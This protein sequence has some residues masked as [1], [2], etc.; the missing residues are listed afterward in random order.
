MN[1]PVISPAPTFQV[2]RAAD[3]ASYDHGWLRTSHSLS[4]AEYYDPQNVNWGRLR[5]FN[6]D[7]VSGGN[8]FGTHPHRDMEILTYVLSGQLEHRDSLGSHGVV[9]PGGVQFMSAGTGI[10]HS[11]VN[12]S[13]NEELH[14][15]Q[16]WIEPGRLG[17]KPLYGQIDFTGEERRGKWLSVASGQSAVQAPVRLTQ[18]A[19]C[20]VSRLEGESL[21]HTFEPER[22]GFLFVAA[23]TIDAVGIDGLGAAAGTEIG[24]AAGDAI[25]ISG[26]PR[27][28]LSGTG[29]VVLWDLPR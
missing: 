7:R 15:L 4:F 28:G 29:E 14:F 21:R 10:R 19:S 11:E 27:L 1:N 25:R 9:G 20:F 12:H 8:G 26:V 24:L 18:D 3:R 17:E 13:E 22:L 6:D 2:Q 23:G 16:M 5:V